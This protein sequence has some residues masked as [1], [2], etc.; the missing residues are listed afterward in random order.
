MFELHYL[1]ADGTITDLDRPLLPV[2]HM[3]TARLLAAVEAKHSDQR[4]Q[5]SRRVWTVPAIT[6][7]AAL[8]VNPDGT[9]DR[10][11]HSKPASKVENCT[12]GTGKVCF[13][14]PCRAERRAIQ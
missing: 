3:S 1:N 12:K 13:C 2:S 10:P 11:L 6:Y 5:I 9:C 8:V 7:K 4:V 14:S